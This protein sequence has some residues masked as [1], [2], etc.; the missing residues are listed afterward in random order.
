MLCS[1][2]GKVVSYPFAD[3]SKINRVE[4]VVPR[5][6]ANLVHILKH[7]RKIC[8]SLGTGWLGLSQLADKGQY[9]G[10]G[11]LGLFEMGHMA[12]LGNPN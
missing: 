1:S 5:E 12:A 11:G 6:G 4:S 3:G 2:L 9:S 7:L 8:C 10:G